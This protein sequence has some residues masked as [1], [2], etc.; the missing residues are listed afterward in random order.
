M[1]SCIRFNLRPLGSCH[2]HSQEC[3]LFEWLNGT[4]VYSYISFNTLISSAADASYSN[5]SVQI[6]KFLTEFESIYV[7]YTE[8]HHEENHNFRK[9]KIMTCYHHHISTMNYLLDA[10]HFYLYVLYSFWSLTAL[11]ELD[12][13]DNVLK[14][15]P[16]SIGKLKSLTR[17]YA[18][19][20]NLSALP[21]RCVLYKSS[22]S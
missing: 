14:T 4:S 22:V 7:W 6:I 8:P 10:P 19:S 13:S 3:V 1:Q 21:E 9:E 5:N 2:I 12:V 20:C 11:E 15:L 18:R 17:F 16:E